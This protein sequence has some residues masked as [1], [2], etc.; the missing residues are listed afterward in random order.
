MFIIPIFFYYFIY[1]ES[2]KTSRILFDDAPSLS[3]ISGFKI[4]DIT[5]DVQVIFITVITFS[6]SLLNS[7]SP[8]LKLDSN[9]PLV[10]FTFA[11]MD[12]KSNFDSPA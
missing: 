4:Y 10:W 12:F 8:I 9:G 3:C 1:V 5:F 7:P 6:F 11:S 2:N